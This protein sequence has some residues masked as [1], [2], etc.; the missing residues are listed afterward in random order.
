MEGFIEALKNDKGY[1]YLA[2]NY[3]SMSKEELKRIAMELLFEL[4]RYHLD[5]LD[6]DINNVIEELQDYI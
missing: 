2:N 4:T 5:G 3:T 1:D 6:P